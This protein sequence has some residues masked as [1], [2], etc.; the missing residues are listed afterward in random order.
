MSVGQ[1]EYITIVTDIKDLHSE[2]F[3]KENRLSSRYN[4]VM[5]SPLP[6]VSLV[7]F[8]DLY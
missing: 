7:A 2:L 5:I 1:F 4:L 8:D 3:S 6:V